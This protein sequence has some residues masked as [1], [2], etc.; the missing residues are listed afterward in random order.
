MATFIAATVPVEKRGEI[1]PLLE[2]AM[3]IGVTDERVT[4]EDTKP[5]TSVVEPDTSDP[6]AAILAAKPIHVQDGSFERF[7]GSFGSPQRWAGR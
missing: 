3:N 6:D 1:S 2:S 4:T 5:T 7:M